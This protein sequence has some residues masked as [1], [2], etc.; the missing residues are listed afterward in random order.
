ML[1]ER[2]RGKKYLDFAEH[3]VAMSENNP[4]LRLMAAMLDGESVVYSGDGKAYQLMA[5][6][7]GYLG[8][9]RNTGDERYLK[10]VQNGWETIKTHHLDVTGGPWSRHM[11][12]NGNR[13]CFALPR[14]FDPAAAY[15]E[16]CSTT[17]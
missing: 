14:D 2:T 11:P 6:L 1:Y 12:Y 10:T 9:Y 8:L 16:T 5:N 13:E 3:I 17:T 4:K 15:V 7:L